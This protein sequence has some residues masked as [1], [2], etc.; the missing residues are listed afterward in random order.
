M[1][2]RYSIII[3]VISTFAAT[4]A[5]AEPTWEAVSLDKSGN[6]MYL[7][8]TS[9]IKKVYGTWRKAWAK[10]YNKVDREIPY[11]TKK[12][13][14]SSLELWDFDCSAQKFTVTSAI[15]YD[16]NGSSVDSMSMQLD[17][18]K[19]IDV[20]PETIAETLMEKICSAKLAK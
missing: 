1:R 12:K 7:L 15:F 17:G 5:I 10:S 19:P 9:S 13:F 20:A 2:L 6:T 3:F 14:S 11:D 4:S 18:A 8:D 16:K